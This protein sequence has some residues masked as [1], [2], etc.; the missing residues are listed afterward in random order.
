MKVIIETP[1][2][3]GYDPCLLE[4]A[5]D[6]KIDFRLQSDGVGGREN[7]RNIFLNHESF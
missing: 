3:E 4:Y 6:V 2:E 7:E 5:L 1:R